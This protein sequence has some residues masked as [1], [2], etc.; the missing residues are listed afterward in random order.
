MYS[1]A[2]KRECGAFL[3]YTGK[4]QLP[5][6]VDGVKKE[7]YSLLCVL[8]HPNNDTPLIVFELVTESLGSE[9]LIAALHNFDSLVSKVMKSCC[10]ASVL[11][12]LVSCLQV[13]GKIVRVKRWNIDCGSNVMRGLCVFANGESAAQYVS[14][15]WAEVRGETPANT[16]KVT[17]AA[18]ALSCSLLERS[19]CAL[20]RTGDNR[21]V[22]GARQKRRETAP[23]KV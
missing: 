17:A 23:A 8:P 5:Y 18:L 11:K 22:L 13:T 3:D 6:I 12:F 19:C 20:V 9:H 16:D 15:R 7:L 2:V 1:L 10:R 4:K 14:R 21:L